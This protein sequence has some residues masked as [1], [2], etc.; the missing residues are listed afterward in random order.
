MGLVFFPVFVNNLEVSSLL[1][2]K[3]NLF[4]VGGETSNFIQFLQVILIAPNDRFPDSQ[5]S[6]FGTA[7]GVLTCNL[8]VRSKPQLLHS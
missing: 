4:Y 7:G 3:H 5:T 1:L 6:T 8:L 2:V